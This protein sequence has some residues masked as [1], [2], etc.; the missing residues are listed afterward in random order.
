[1]PLSSS[2]VSDNKLFQS[3]LTTIFLTERHAIQERRFVKT[4]AAAN[5]KQLVLCQDQSITLHR[6]PNAKEF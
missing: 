4:G 2:F 6:E 1:M 5:Q 3:K